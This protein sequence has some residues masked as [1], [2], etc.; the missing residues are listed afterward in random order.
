MSYYKKRCMIMGC[1]S[2]AVECTNGIYLCKRHRSRKLD[3]NEVYLLK[4]MQ[5]VRFI[6]IK[7]KNKVKK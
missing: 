6:D 4:N 7:E 2:K 5:R 3:S 1:K